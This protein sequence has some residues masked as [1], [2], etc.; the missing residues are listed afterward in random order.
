M[1]QKLAE[2]SVKALAEGLCNVMWVGESPAARNAYLDD[3][4]SFGEEF[5][6]GAALIASWLEDCTDMPESKED[7][8]H[9]ICNAMWHQR[10][11]AANNFRD[12]EEFR[13]EFERAAG[14]VGRLFPADYELP[15]VDRSGA[16][17]VAFCGPSG[18]GKSVLVK[19][20]LEAFP[21]QCSMWQQF[22][23]RRRREREGRLDY[24]FLD[25]K[26]YLRMYPMLTCRTH[27]NGSDYGTIPEAHTAGRAIL[28][29]ADAG[30]LQDLEQD[31]KRHNEQIENGARSG[32]FGGGYV[33][34][35]KVYLGY[36]ISS[37]T[38]ESRG[39][40]SRG[41]SFVLDEVRRLNQFSFD[42]EISSALGQWPD[43]VQFFN[44]HIRR[45]LPLDPAFAVEE[46]KKLL[47]QA[48]ACLE[49]GD[50]K[51]A[52][53]LVEAV[54]SWMEGSGFNEKPVDDIDAEPGRLGE[55]P[56]DDIDAAL[57][58]KLEDE[59]EGVPAAEFEQLL[60]FEPEQPQAP[61]DEGFQ[62]PPETHAPITPDAGPAEA[63]PAEAPP[64]VFHDLQSLHSGV[65]FELWILRN[66]M[67]MQPFTGAAEF[68]RIYRTYVEANH[69]ILP[70]SVTY[71]FLTSGGEK[72]GRKVTFVAKSG[73]QAVTMVWDEKL[74]RLT[75]P[76]TVAAA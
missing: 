60:Q 66:G 40:G 33:K 6:R 43:A 73:G 9:A 3:P 14:W 76:P 7:I 52:H 63:P 68:E 10:N 31:V 37:L 51:F 72:G 49:V 18:G 26:Q 62:G 45:H 32:K 42:V 48:G 22:T 36:D 71:S 23:T 75:T 4:L 1:S 11:P 17:I 74:K 57:D 69:A 13:E 50:P 15:E 67:G 24:V 20:L 53:G 2:A 70:G 58:E 64:A 44:R 29:I 30:G 39:R 34:L 46:A 55:K 19:S 21:D 25:R 65:D 12:S 56:V 38:V 35:I 54:R 41:V 47:S 28:T 27:F 16:L 8:A 59:D 5:E 61:A